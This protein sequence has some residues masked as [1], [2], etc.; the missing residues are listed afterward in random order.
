[1]YSIFQTTKKTYKND[2]AW[3]NNPNSEST[4]IT[5]DQKAGLAQ[6]DD[7]GGGEFISL[8]D[9]NFT[10]FVTAPAPAPVATSTAN[11]SNH[12]N[13]WEDYDDLSIGN[14]AFGSKKKNDQTTDSVA[15]TNNNN[16][17]TKNDISQTEQEKEEKQ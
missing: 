3:W 6:T 12:N 7:I 1:M 13:N 11:S 2:S 5:E 17:E 15:D 10:P 16:V 9:N 14:N 4:N 8:M